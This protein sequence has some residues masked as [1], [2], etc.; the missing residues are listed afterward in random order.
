MKKYK[1]K[2]FELLYLLDLFLFG[3]PTRR[4]RCLVSDLS[5]DILVSLIRVSDAV[6]ALSN[7]A[8][9][10]RL[11]LSA[12]GSAVKELLFVGLPR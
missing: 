3:D 6:L 2:I 9:G 10:R 1:E 4:G 5:L 12:R 7:V 8:I 11:G